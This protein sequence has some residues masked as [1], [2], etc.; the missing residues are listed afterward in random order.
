[1]KIRLFMAAAAMVVSTSTA[2]ATPGPG[3]GIPHETRRAG[4]R[5]SVVTDNQELM[6]KAANEQSRH[7]GKAL[8]GPNWER[9]ANYLEH[10]GQISCT[11]RTPANG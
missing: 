8:S 2:F 6:C 11:T 10:V 5:L 9:T 4:D 3:S 7:A 1:M